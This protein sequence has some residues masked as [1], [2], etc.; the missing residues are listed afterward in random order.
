MAVHNYAH[1]FGGLPPGSFVTTSPGG[2]I[3]VSYLGPQARILPFLEQN[4][5]S[6]AMNLDTSYGNLVNKADRPRD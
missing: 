6:E 5:V 2:A 4:N 1:T 3:W